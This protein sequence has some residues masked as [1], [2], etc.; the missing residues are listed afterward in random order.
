[1]VLINATYYRRL[2]CCWDRKDSIFVKRHKIRTEIDNICLENGNMLKREVVASL[3]ADYKGQISNNNF[4]Q[5]VSLIFSAFL[6]VLGFIVNK[7]YQ[8]LS[9]FLIIMIVIS[10][11][12]IC[13]RY[14][15]AEGFVLHIL[16]DY[17]K[18]I[19]ENEN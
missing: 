12:L 15:Y 8:I 6:L 14:L 19:D 3:I 1:M 9:V 7:D 16:E 11:T 10:I 5:F 2:A 13:M 4:M 18:E 17:S